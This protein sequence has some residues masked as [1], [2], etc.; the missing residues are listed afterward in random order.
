[1]NKEPYLDCKEVYTYELSDGASNLTLEKADVH[2]E[3]VGMNNPKDWPIAIVTE[4]GK[5]LVFSSSFDVCSSQWQKRHFELY[6]PKSQICHNLPNLPEQPIIPQNCSSIDVRSYTFLKKNVFYLSTDDGGVFTLDLKRKPENCVWRRHRFYGS[7][8]IARHRSLVVIDNDIRLLPN[9]AI[10]IPPDKMDGQDAFASLYYLFPS[11]PR[12]IPTHDIT[13]SAITLLNYKQRKDFS[14]CILQV[15]A[16][17]DVMDPERKYPEL[18]IHA[19]HTQLPKCKKKLSKNR[20]KKMEKE[21]SPLTR[22][23]E[24]FELPNTSKLI[25]FKFRVT[26]QFEMFSLLSFGKVSNCNRRSKRSRA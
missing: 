9:S 16:S 7:A 11:L 5:I 17:D 20:K 18:I 12:C 13:Y 15:G 19:Y 2:K 4:D 25:S 3:G 22:K 8:G 14:V 1:M 21:P 6:D 24:N 10:Y 23:V 26:E